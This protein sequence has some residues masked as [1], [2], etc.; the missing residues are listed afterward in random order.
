MNLNGNSGV[1]SYIINKDSIDVLFKGNN[2]IYRYSYQSAGKYNVDNMI[3]LAIRGY[4]L[5]GYINLYCRNLY[6]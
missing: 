1:D 2:R 4:G 6:E 5:N 3:K